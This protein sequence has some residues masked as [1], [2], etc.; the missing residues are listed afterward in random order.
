MEKSILCVLQKFSFYVSQRRESHLVWHDTMGRVNNDRVHVCCAWDGKWRHYTALP[1]TDSRTN[2][3]PNTEITRNR[4][5]HTHSLQTR[6]S[7]VGAQE[8][9]SSLLCMIQ[10]DHSII[11]DESVMHFTL[12]TCSLSESV[13]YYTYCYKSLLD[14]T[15]RQLFS[16]FFFFFFLEYKSENA[17][18]LLMYVMGT[19][20]L[21][22]DEREDDW[23]I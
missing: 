20:F 21:S 12:I 19:S 14:E 17:L 4:A 10:Y 15:L 5:A 7:C 2:T 16:V 6:Q 11:D 3:N 9:P 18:L 13:L 22:L 1:Q 23:G 8:R